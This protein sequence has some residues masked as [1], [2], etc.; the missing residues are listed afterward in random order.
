MSER[1]AWTGTMSAMRMQLLGPQGAEVLTV[2]TIG[3]DQ[4]RELRQEARAEIARLL[5]IANTCSDALRHTSKVPNDPDYP[6]KISAARARC[7]EI[8]N[9]RRGL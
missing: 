4:I 6:E 1:C 9:A 3:N 7:A 5:E 8:L 2:D